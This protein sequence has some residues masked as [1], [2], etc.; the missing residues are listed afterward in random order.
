MRRAIGEIFITRGARLAKLIGG[1]FEPE[2]RDA[3]LWRLKRIGRNAWLHH[4]PP[5][6]HPIASAAPKVVALPHGVGTIARTVVGRLRLGIDSVERF[7]VRV[8]LLP[9]VFLLIE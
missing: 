3:Q 2:R 5:V 1:L 9:K 6:E 7:F 8:W 4:V